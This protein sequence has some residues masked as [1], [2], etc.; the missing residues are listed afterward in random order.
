MRR[1]PKSYEDFRLDKLF[2]KKAIEGVKIYII[3]YNEPK[4]ALTINSGYT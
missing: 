3:V 2:E 1:P 4:V